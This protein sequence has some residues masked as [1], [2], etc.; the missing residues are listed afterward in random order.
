MG[1]STSIPLKFI[2]RQSYL[3]KFLRWRVN[4]CT[5]CAEENPREVDNLK[6]TKNEKV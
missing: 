5:A 1:T 3:K 2:I 6:R 4:I